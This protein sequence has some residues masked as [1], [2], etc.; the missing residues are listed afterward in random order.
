MCISE[1]TQTR[2]HMTGEVETE[3]GKLLSVDV[4]ILYNR[5]TAP[6]GDTVV[7]TV[8]YE[9]EDQKYSLDGVYMTIDELSNVFKD[10]HIAEEYI[11]QAIESVL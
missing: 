7:E 9:I 5:D 1:M 3:C 10:R 6:Y 4:E 8:E 2:E 11:T